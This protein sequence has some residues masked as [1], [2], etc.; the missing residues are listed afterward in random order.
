MYKKISNCLRRENLPVAFP[1]WLGLWRSQREVAKFATEAIHSTHTRDGRGKAILAPAFRAG[2]APDSGN[3][4]EKAPMVGAAGRIEGGFG[5]VPG[6]H[7]RR[8]VKRC[9]GEKGDAGTRYSGSCTEIQ[10]NSLN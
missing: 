9:R 8:G 4:E 1:K 2:R 6:V 7:M 5:G 10:S 3:R